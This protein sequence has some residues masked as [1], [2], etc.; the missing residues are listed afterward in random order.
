MN[1]TIGF[2]DRGE[3]AATTYTLGIPHPTGY[4]TF[5]LLG[6]LVAHSIPARPVLVLNAFAA[7][8]VAVS[9]AGLVLLFD[10]L[11]RRASK[12]GSSD[13]DHSVLALLSA[14]FTA[15]TIRWWQQ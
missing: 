10:D 9:A 4:P 5:T 7:F 15:F 6:W 8:L 3:L 11:F 13:E 14:L 2:I 12:T 1:R